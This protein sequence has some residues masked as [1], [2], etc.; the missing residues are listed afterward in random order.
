MT[1]SHLSLAEEARRFLQLAGPMIV[2]RVGLAGMSVA[3]GVMVAQFSPSGTHELAVLGLAEGTTGR[4]LDVV[5]AL[6]IAGMTMA[7]RPGGDPAHSSSVWRQA[8]MLALAGGLIAM[9]LS[10]TAPW[11]LPLAGQDAS[12]IAQGGAVSVVL[13]LGFAAALVA[14]ATAGYLEVTGRAYTVVLAVTLAN[15]ANI[16]LNWVFISGALGFPAMGAVG[17]AWATTLVRWLMATGLFIYVWNLRDHQRLGVRQRWSAKDWADG[18]G[19]RLRGYSAT[20][21][22]LILNILNLTI[23]LMAGSLGGASMAALKAVLLIL[24]PCSIVIW[25][26]S[27]ATGVRVSA[28]QG[29]PNSLGPR[30]TTWLVTGLSAGLVLIM[31][32]P[33]LLTPAAISAW[34]S[35]DP[36][37]VKTVSS[38]LLIGVATVLCDAPGFAL[39]AALRS[40]GE[41]KTLFVLDVLVSVLLVLAAWWLAFSLESGV[42]GLLW[43]MLISRGLRTLALAAVFQLRTRNYSHFTAGLAKP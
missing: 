28:S 22:A 11:W 23:P 38:L 36:E 31:V 39:S 30:S 14:L 9:L 26:L 37:L 33:F 2:S 27:D 43:A 25:G 13:G 1:V 10:F 40:L 21:Q 15:L 3:D 20:A 12:L 6:V 16:G 8:L 4:A 29:N 32:L 19:Q 34:L 5:A 41:L 24:T 35:S 7:A 17:C 18:K 42:A